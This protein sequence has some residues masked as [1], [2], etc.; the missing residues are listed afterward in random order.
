MSDQLRKVKEILPERH[1]EGEV[2]GSLAISDH[3]L[4]ALARA[5]P[6]GEP[7]PEVLAYLTDY[8]LNEQHPG[9]YGSPYFRHVF[10]WVPQPW[11][12]SDLASF[13]SLA[14]LL[15]N[16]LKGLDT[17][18]GRLRGL[19]DST[20]GEHLVKLDLVDTFGVRGS[21]AEELSGMAPKPKLR[22]LGLGTNALDDD[23]VVPLL[24][25]GLFPGLWD[26]ELSVNDVTDRTAEALA[27]CE[28][29]TDLETLEL[30]HTSVTR[31][32][33]ERIA[34]ASALPRNATYPFAEASMS[35]SSWSAY[36]QGENELGFFH[37]R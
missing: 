13:P 11:I 27:R 28:T 5:I 20:M 7:E 16:A 2:E 15:C 4:E 6:Q 36:L 23:D 8:V 24:E 1:V 32:G 34:N 22:A 30:R 12:P 26:L 9:F 10:T 17:V 21:I 3:M 18:D 33:A 25:A 19:F 35:Q 31:A 37:D 14:L 29:L